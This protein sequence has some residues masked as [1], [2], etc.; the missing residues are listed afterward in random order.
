MTEREIRS[1]INQVSPSP[2]Y[3]LNLTKVELSD[4]IFD[5]TG[6][7]LEQYEQN[8]S[9]NAKRLATFLSKLDKP[10]ADKVTTALLERKDKQ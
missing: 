6:M 1:F 3:I 7:E 8:G 9:S 4:L 2:G 5:L 10:L